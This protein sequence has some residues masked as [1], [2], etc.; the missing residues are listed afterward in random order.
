M[1]PTGNIRDFFKPMPRSLPK[2]TEAVSLSKDELPIPPSRQ[3]PSASIKNEASIQDE[4]PQA[5]TSQR[6][7]RS[8]DDEESNSDCSLED[9]KDLLQ[10]RNAT[11]GTK[12][13]SNGLKPSTNARTRGRG[14]RPATP[15]SPLTV[16]PR[17]QFD[18]KTLVS[19]AE[20][21]EAAEASALSLQALLEETAKSGSVSPSSK[22]GAAHT[23]ILE[24]VVAEQEGASLEKVLQAVKRT[25]ATQA[26]KRCYVFEPYEE[27]SKPTMPMPEIRALEGWKQSLADPRQREHIVLSDF[28]RD[29]IILGDVLPDDLFLWILDEMCLESRDDLREAYSRILMASKLQIHKLISPETVINVFRRLGVKELGV[30]TKQKL[31]LASL[32]NGPYG[33]RDWTNMRATIIFISKISDHLSALTCAYVICLLARLCVDTAV[34]ET[35][36]LLSAVQKT[37]EQASKSL[38]SRFWENSVRPS[39]VTIISKSSRFEV[40]GDLCINISCH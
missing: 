29:M 38:D 9:L 14:R 10:F 6:I 39:P 3:R 25:E 23:G 27:N 28:A 11:Q 37:M 13:N 7:I 36:G 33:D 24:S 15:N 16:K 26:E 17:Y 19:Q 30:D 32:E 35:I 40:Q 12:P 1:A 34:L 2:V 18:M 4:T 22:S 31:K 21:Y 5:S 20:M 8:S